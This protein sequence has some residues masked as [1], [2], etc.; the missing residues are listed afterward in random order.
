M[1]QV[2]THGAVIGVLP[3]QDFAQGLSFIELAGTHKGLGKAAIEVGRFRLWLGLLDLPEFD[4]SRGMVLLLEKAQTE[5]VTGLDEFRVYLDGVAQLK[6]G[7]SDLALIVEGLALFVSLLH[8]HFGV[9]APRKNRGK[10]Q[11]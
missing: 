4:D 10:N 5:M 9:A 1:G 6:H 3:Q 11:G 8:A 2:P 7:A